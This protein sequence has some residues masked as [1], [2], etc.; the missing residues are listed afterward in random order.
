MVFGFTEAVRTK[1]WS[2]LWGFEKIVLR[3][4][5][6]RYEG[7]QST[8]KDLKFTSKEPLSILDL[9]TQMKSLSPNSSWLNDWTT[10]DSDKHSHHLADEL[11]TIFLKFWDTLCL[12]SKSKTT[13][14]RYSSALHA[15]GG[16]LVHIAPIQET[17]VDSTR[18]FLL[19]NISREGGPLIF[20]REET[21]QNELDTVCKKLHKHLKEAS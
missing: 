2:Q 15:L 17:K 12:S 5:N 20:Y 16:H 1:P 6:S 8:S 21:W 14:Y 9:A 3:I 18:L 4:Q 11:V 19:E 13:Q 10:D 7:N